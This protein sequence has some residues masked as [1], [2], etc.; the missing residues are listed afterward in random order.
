MRTSIL[1][2]HI[3]RW[4]IVGRKHRLGIGKNPLLHVLILKLKTMHLYVFTTVDM[5]GKQKHYLKYCTYPKRTKIYWECMEQL[6][7][8][9]IESFSFSKKGEKVF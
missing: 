2:T 1:K 4:N 6:E 5:R 8:D 7:C 3:G 9:E